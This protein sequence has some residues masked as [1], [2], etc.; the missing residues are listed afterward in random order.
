MIPRID[1]RT[2]KLPPGIYEATW[3]EIVA[4]YGTTAHRRG[5]LAGLKRALDNLQAAGCRRVYI[6]G[7][8]ITNKRIP[9]D[10][11][12]C[13][14]GV[15]VQRALL[16]PALQT[17][18]PGNATQKAAFGCEFFVAETRADL[19]GTRML[20]FFQRDK[21]TGRPKGIIALDLAELP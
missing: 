9:G 16:D 10:I 6:D 7:S 13:Y 2:G 15:G 12:C 4:R 18:E 11:D 21:L 17:Y 19:R 3:E 5:L 20:E 1:E 14:E 8:F